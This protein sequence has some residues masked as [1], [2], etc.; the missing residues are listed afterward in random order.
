ML[1]MLPDAIQHE[2]VCLLEN[3]VTLLKKQGSH[4]FAVHDLPNYDEPERLIIPVLNVPMQP[5]IIA[6]HP[7]L[8]GPVIALVE[9]ST[10]LGDEACGRR[11]QAFH[12][13]ARTHDG[14]LM[15]FVHPEDQP[16]AAEIARH[17]HI[18]L[19]SI[20]TVPRNTHEPPL[21]TTANP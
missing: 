3:V 16:R 2:R 9:V 19:A 5:D 11:W 21:E 10:D 14:R 20:V 4:D 17:W 15:V 7:Q 18:D 8:Q 1:N 6:H 12:D 13:W